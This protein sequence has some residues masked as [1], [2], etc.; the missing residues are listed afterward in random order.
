MVYTKA[1][2]GVNLGIVYSYPQYWGFSKS[3]LRS[4]IWVRCG[5][6]CSSQAASG[7]CLFAKN[8]KGISRRGFFPRRAVTTQDQKT[9]H[10][11]QCTSF[12][13]CRLNTFGDIVDLVLR[14]V[15]NISCPKQPAESGVW[16]D[17]VERSFSSKAGRDRA[18]EGF[19]VMVCR[20]QKESLFQHIEW[21]H[22][23]VLFNS[24]PGAIPMACIMEIA[25]M[26]RCFI[27]ICFRL[28]INLRIFSYQ[29]VPRTRRGGSS[30]HMQ[31]L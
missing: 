13:V 1:I 26:S 24:S 20:L 29:I 6:G 17:S 19:S 10:W 7:I 4:H 16:F 21:Q 28:P 11:L 5:T 2:S 14:W 31:Q 3:I 23:T 12:L 9:H 8:P 18:N 25:T 27:R 30:E 22:D 15:L